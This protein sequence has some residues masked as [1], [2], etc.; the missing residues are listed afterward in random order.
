MGK[1]L[2][3]QWRRRVVA[4]GLAG[5]AFFAVPVAVAAA[6]GFGSSLS[7]VAGGLGAIAEGPTSTST[8]TASRFAPNK[9][10]QAVKGLA[11]PE[12]SR[13]AAVGDAPTGTEGGSGGG[14]GGG[15]NLGSGGSVVSG[16]GTGGKESPTISSPP[17][18][19]I[20]LPG[21]SS[22]GETANQINSSVTNLLDGVNSTVNG[23][24]GGQ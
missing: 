2:L 24:L 20:P 5:A 13:A 9:L 17:A 4:R 1:G 18:P 19:D 7:G 16:Q 22:A 12:A 11:A 3:A 8:T 6:I 10:N 14:A 21:G 15:S 23:L